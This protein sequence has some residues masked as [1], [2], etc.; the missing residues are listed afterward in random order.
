MKT[1]RQTIVNCALEAAKRSV[2][3]YQEMSGGKTV[4]DH[5]IETFISS[6]VA[7]ALYDLRKD[8]DATVA[9]EAPFHEVHALSLARKGRMPDILSPTARFDICYFEGGRPIGVIEVKKRFAAFKADDDINRLFLAT[10]RFGPKYGGSIKFGIW[11]A[12]QRI[13]EGS[14]STA[15][16]QIAK[17]LQSFE[18]SVEPSIS[19][20]EVEG[21]FGKLKKSGKT[22]TKLRIFAASFDAKEM[23]AD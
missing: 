18:W 9:L 6:K 19:H 8:H 4:H 2:S 7:E 21:E 10:R 23:K 12:L 17:F 20:R 16:A 3:R 1:T 13:P 5:A 22:A 14:K 15:K 11:L